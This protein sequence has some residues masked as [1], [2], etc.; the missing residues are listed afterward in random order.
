MTRLFG[1]FDKE[2]GRVVYSNEI[3]FYNRKRSAQVAED[4]IPPTESPIDGTI[5]NSKSAL[6]EHYRQHG[7]ECTGGSH[8]T[9]KGLA[10][11][12][13]KA[14]VDQARDMAHQIESQVKWGMFPFD[15]RDKQFH[16]EEERRYKSGT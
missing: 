4:T 7:Y 9:G 3:E 5:F 12:K 2:L 8:L 6:Y 15:E 13:Y 1:R 14:D 11:M 16:I 10:D